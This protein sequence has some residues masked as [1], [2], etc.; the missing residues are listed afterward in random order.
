MIYKKPKIESEQ[1]KWQA[2]LYVRLSREDDNGEDESLSISNQKKFLEQYVKN[3]DDVEIFDIYCDDGFSGGNFNRPDFQRM[4][5]DI[6][7]R[8]INCVIVKDTSRLGRNNTDIG[9]YT[10]KLFPKYDV[11]YIS[12]TNN[13]DS[14][15]DGYD[16]LVNDVNNMMSAEYLRDTSRKI[17]ASLDTSRKLGEFIGSFASYGYK[18]DPEDRHRLIIDEDAAEVVRL[19]Y[20]WFLEGKSIR[21]IAVELNQMG[22]PNPSTYKKN[23]GLNYRHPGTVDDGLWPDSSVRRI[24]Q[25]QMYT[26]NMVQGKTRKYSIF[27]KAL[28]NVPEEDWIIV[29]NTHEAIIDFDTFVKAQS[30]FNSNIRKSP[31]SSEV[32][33]F[34]GLVKCA[35]CGRAMTKKTNKHSYGLYEYY[36]CS[37][38][39]KMGSDRCTN[40]TIRIDKL[41]E[42]VTATIQ[43]MIETAVDLDEVLKLI[44]NNPKKIQQ[45]KIYEDSIEKLKQERENNFKEIRQLHGNLSKGLITEEQFKFLNGEILKTDKAL[46]SRIAEAEK[47]LDEFDNSDESP[48][49]FIETFKKYG[50]FQ[51][52]TRPM[53]LELVDEILVEEHG[54]IRIKFKFQDVYKEALDYIQ[55]NEDI[56]KHSA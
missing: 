4:V 15:R 47:H 24:L 33:L 13:Y 9:Q 29:E 34:A 54:K 52:L 32:G 37:T 51:K 53:L 26:G 5:S 49:D 28:K 14:K 12:V 55:A 35:D 27:E 42:A 3:L 50:N 22:V 38:A 56:V 45:S 20:R 36:K 7:S 10:N 2:A 40:H 41:T 31:N 30:L 25:N 39:K 6:E 46:A 48:N 43:K 44:K 1:K 23:Q 11:R 21:G 18:K 16:S 17:R 8:K 19:I